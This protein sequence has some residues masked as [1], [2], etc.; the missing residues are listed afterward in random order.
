MDRKETRTHRRKPFSYAERLFC[1]CIFG[2]GLCKVFDNAVSHIK[3]LAIKYKKTAA[4]N[5]C[6]CILL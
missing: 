3:S 1:L 2:K 6:R 5:V 4:D